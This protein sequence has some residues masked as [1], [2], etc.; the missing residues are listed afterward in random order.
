MLDMQTDRVA[1][2]IGD[3][4]SAEII[5]D[6]QRHGARGKVGFAYMAG[7][8][9]FWDQSPGALWGNTKQ[10]GGRCFGRYR[11]MKGINVQVSA[12]RAERDQIDEAISA[13]RQAITS[14]RGHLTARRPVVPPA[15]SMGRS[16]VSDLEAARA[17]LSVHQAALTRL[18]ARRDRVES[19]LGSAKA[20]Q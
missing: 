16:A 19:E 13:E 10:R 1:K 6:T 4:R 20:T 11:R 14:L 15:G 2:D 18:E 3:L 7:P 9:T 12:L 5:I 17:A 8:T